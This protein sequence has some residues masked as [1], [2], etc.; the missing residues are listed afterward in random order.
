LL[1]IGYFCVIIINSWRKPMLQAPLLSTDYQTLFVSASE[2]TV[3]VRHQDISGIHIGVDKPD[4]WEV[5]VRNSGLHVVQTK[6]G[7]RIDISVPCTYRG[8]LEITAARS[9]V[10]LDYWTGTRCALAACQD[11]TFTTG[12]L[13]TSVAAVITGYSN[14]T[15]EIESIDST[16]F[17]SNLFETSWAVIHKAIC[18]QME[19]FGSSNAGLYIADGAA[20]YGT[21]CWGSQRDI[22]LRGSFAGVS[23]TQRDQGVIRMIDTFGVEEAEENTEDEDVDALV[24]EVQLLFNQCLFRAALQAIQSCP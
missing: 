17:A 15:L 20:E 10:K 6:G 2:A 14:G 16:L 5:S 12:E 8:A 13:E 23:S 18:E 11:S 4:H 3:T 9:A 24:Q 21:I 22:F 1:C 19:V 7:G